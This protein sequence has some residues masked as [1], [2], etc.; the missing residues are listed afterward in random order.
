LA[1]FNSNPVSWF[2]Y[3][4]LVLCSNGYPN[5]MVIN[6]INDILHLLFRYCSLRL[7]PFVWFTS[8][9]LYVLSYPTQYV[10]HI[11]WYIFPFLL[12]VTIKYGIISNIIISL[13]PAF[14]SAPSFPLRLVMIHIIYVVFL[15]HIIMICMS[16]STV[17]LIIYLDIIITYPVHSF[18]SIIPSFIPSVTPIVH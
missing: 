17:Q 16:H 2:H 11:N 13:C 9:T 15:T 5:H 10:Y 6:N 14:Q 12:S 4:P 8:H 1:Y 7:M 3:C 18:M